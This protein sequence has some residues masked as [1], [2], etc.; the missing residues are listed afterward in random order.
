[1][2]R[3]N[4]TGNSL[5]SADSKGVGSQLGPVSGRERIQSI[6]VLRGFSLLGILA[7]NIYFFALPSGVYFDPTIAGG[8]TGVNL[9][10]WKATYLFFLQK[11]MSIFSMLFGAG[12][13]L[14][15]DRAETAGKSLR[16]MYYRRILWLLIFGLAHGFLF[17]HGDILFTYAVCGFLLYLFR[18]RSPRALIIWA[19][20]FLSLGILI[21]MGSAMHFDRLRAA[22]NQIE[23]ARASGAEITTELSSLTQVWEETKSYFV[24]TPGEV[25]EEVNSY[26]GNFSEV[27]AY[28]AP[29]TLMMQTQAMIFMVFWRA[30]G[31]M[32]LGM[33]LMKLGVFSGKRS[34][35][36]YVI[37]IIAGYGIGLPLAHYGATQLIANNFDFIYG[38]RI[39]YH[40]NYIAG[41]LVSLG[42]VGLVMVVYRSGLLDWLME[43]LA[44]VGRMA[45]SNYLLH[46][47][48]CTTIFYGYGLGL[49]NRVERFGLMGFVLAIWIFQLIIS[50]IWLRHFRFGP[51]EWLWRSLTYKRRQ[52]MRV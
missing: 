22:V 30:M 15:H 51:A 26:R 14:M 32:L 25:V 9:F 27:M 46:T 48:V 18:N 4:S 13:I 36:F 23:A 7:I 35:R 28:R 29:K 34:V 6:D 31:L 1:M 3:D 20:V 44:A 49:F 2:G 40:F 12:L 39:G 50:P 52:P 45:L 41:V 17:W 10:T 47:I 38:F 24:P 43:R 33:A 37:C 21:Q 11:M 5:S 42:H 16:G 8:F 19:V